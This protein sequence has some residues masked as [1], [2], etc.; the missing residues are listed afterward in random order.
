MSSSSAVVVPRTT[1]LP[2][3][4]DRAITVREELNHG[5]HT[6]MLARMYR[7]GDTGALRVDPVK[8]GDAL[9]VAYL[10]DWTLT[11][12]SGAP[13]EIRGLPPDE[14][15]DVLNNLR[16]PIVREI[17]DAIAK[18]HDAIEAADAAQK[19]TESGAPASPPTSPSAAPPA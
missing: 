5:Q 6:A 12:A 14:L 10:V 13:L 1:T 4:R 16:H 17:K 19:K 18:H 15:Q 7:E 2:L 8:Q 3:S 11:D 9:I